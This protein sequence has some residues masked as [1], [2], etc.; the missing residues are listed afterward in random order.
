MI[1]FKSF[2]CFLFSI[3]IFLT[4]YGFLYNLVEPKAYDFMTKHF[5]TK[6]LPFDNHKKIYGSDNIVLVIIDAKTVE[7][8]RW[9]WKRESYC[10]IFEYFNIAKPKLI[11]YDA[12]ITTLDKEN[13]TS[14]KKFFKSINKLDNLIVGF[15]P[16]FTNWENPNIGEKI[17]I[18]F[19]N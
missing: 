18:A 7:K 15:M 6:K 10:K 13:V 8:Y 4:I 1:K 11:V 17:D 3:I 19:I 12:I 2:F 14:D 5:V 9:P 16:R